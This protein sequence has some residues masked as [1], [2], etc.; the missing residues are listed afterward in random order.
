MAALLAALLLAAQCRSGTPPPQE[1]ATSAAPSASSE[2]A[3][4]GQSERASSGSGSEFPSPDPAAALRDGPPKG[5]SEAIPEDG[6]DPRRDVPETSPSLELSGIEWI[7]IPSQLD[8]MR[9]TTVKLSLTW[10]PPH[11]ET[12]ECSWDPGDR[13]GVI[14]GCEVT[15]SFQGGLVDR[16]VGVKV[17][18]AGQVVFEDHRLLP[19]ERLSVVPLDDDEEEPIQ[20]SADALP[21]PPDD[22]SGLR[23]VFVGL[24]DSDP[25]VP[26][27]VL[28]VLE[29]VDPDLV[30][31]FFNQST[32]GD[33]VREAT[34]AVQEQTRSPVV[35]LPMRWAAPDF[36]SIPPRSKA[37]LPH[38]SDNDFPRRHAFLMRGVLFIFL[39][40]EITDISRKQEKWLS[41]QLEAGKVA[42]HRVVV[43]PYPI[44]PHVP[45]KTESLV[46]DFRYY[47]KL[48]RGDVSLVVSSNIPL[49]YHGR[50]GQLDTLSAGV[51][52]GQPVQPD[53]A[54]ESQ[55]NLVTVV[56]LT[57][58]A[59]P[60][61]YPIG[62]EA[63][64][65]LPYSRFPEKLG[66]YRRIP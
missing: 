52:T 11:P 18:V 63:G 53:P 59:L 5:A 34:N 22:D 10:D 4:M 54:L 50:Y 27:A 47:E 2:S 8:V 46:P 19:L 42:S 25:S 41:D 24:H 56:D 44:K 21:P 43:S 38:G 55:P 66:V 16:T 35:P 45:G 64:D 37:L 32:Q 31:L 28:N 20:F 14:N 13:T 26:T 12:F 33:D 36:S 65:V 7:A 51:A 48:M 6:P 23:C 58:G 15:H 61:V 62:V 1:P 29:D 9:D 57:A 17:T 49:Y 30:V 3:T 40:P 60:K 39:D